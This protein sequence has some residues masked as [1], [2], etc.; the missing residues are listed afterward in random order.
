M[1]DARLPEEF[2]EGFIPGSINIGLNG[3]F[4]IWVGTLLDIEKPMIV[5]ASAG[6]ESETVLRLARVGYEKVRGVLQ[7]GFSAWLAAG[8]SIDTIDSIGPDAAADLSDKG[9]LVVDV[10][11]KD[12]FASGHVKEAMNIPLHQLMAKAERLDPDDDF[13][14]HCKGG[15]R[16][17]IAASILKSKGI[18]NFVN[19]LGGYDALLKTRISI[20]EPLTK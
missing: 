13:V 7:G 18:D 5:V 9:L 19:V 20:E 1:L 8:F 4:A 14:L 6:K 16:S 3:Q 11:N 12:E 2:A 10:R 17:M 15:Y